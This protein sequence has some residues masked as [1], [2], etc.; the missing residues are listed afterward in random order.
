MVA[1]FQFLRILK[2]QILLSMYFESTK[3]F[4]T[5]F[6]AWVNAN[7]AEGREDQSGMMTME[8]EAADEPPDGINLLLS[9]IDQIKSKL[10]GAGPNTDPFRTLPVLQESGY[11]SR[12]PNQHSID[13]F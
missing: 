10:N 11:S 12:Q 9:P 6:W 5:L 13:V 2:F 8:T 3:I 7:P 4:W 1:S